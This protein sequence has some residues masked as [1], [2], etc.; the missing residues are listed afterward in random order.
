[1]KLEMI[2]KDGTSVE[3]IEASYPKH[4]VLQCKNAAAFKKVWNKMTDE[5][6][7]EIHIFENETEKAIVVGSKVC[8]TQTVNIPDGMYGHFY[9][10]GGD[11]Y[12]PGEYPPVFDE[13]MED[14]AETTDE[15][16]EET[17]EVN[18]ESVEETS[19]TVEA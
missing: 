13:E 10:E 14:G 16:V 19:E 5:N 1:M 11:V 7:S 9:L 6:T 17:A 8:G 2:L 4:Y 12:A 15:P 3:L 18:N